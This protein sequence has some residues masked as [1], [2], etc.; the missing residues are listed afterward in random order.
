MKTKTIQAPNRKLFDTL[1]LEAW[2]LS[3]Y[4]WVFL[5]APNFTD[6]DDTIWYQNLERKES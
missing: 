6:G 2:G 1:N 3:N 4:V 5:G